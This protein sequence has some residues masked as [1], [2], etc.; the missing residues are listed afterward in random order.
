MVVASPVEVLCICQ[1]ADVRCVFTTKPEC[2]AREYETRATFSVSRVGILYV[3]Y[4]N[5]G[6]ER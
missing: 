3:C 5:Q 4:E 2:V 6:L 1:E